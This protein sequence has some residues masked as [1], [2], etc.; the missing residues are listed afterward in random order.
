[1]QHRNYAMTGLYCVLKRSFVFLYILSTSTLSHKNP[2]RQSALLFTLVL[3]IIASN[4]ENFRLDSFMGGFG[5]IV[6]RRAIILA[7]CNMYTVGDT[8][9]NQL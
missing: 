8:V 2:H 6:M 4:F 5:G 3:V 1:M 9:S 7:V